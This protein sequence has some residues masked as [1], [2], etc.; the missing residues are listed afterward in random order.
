[1]HLDYKKYDSATGMLFV[2]GLPSC[3]TMLRSTRMTLSYTTV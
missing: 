2:L 3:D 1:M